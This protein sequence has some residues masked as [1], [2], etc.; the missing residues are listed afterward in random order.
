MK[1]TWKTVDLHGVVIG[2]GSTIT[3][4]KEN[5][6]ARIQRAFADTDYNPRFVRFPRGE[7]GTVYHTLEGWTY[8]I[9]WSDQQEKLEYGTGTY[10][11]KQEALWFLKRHVAQTYVLDTEDDG[12]SILDP[13]DTGG[14][15]AH[16]RYIRFQRAY[17]EL[18]A[19]GHDPDTC[20]RLACQ[21]S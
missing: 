13:L 15:E 12:L 10:D 20:H 3:R 7:V 2:Q 9:L 1:A 18:K 8:G 5:A 6:V 19:Q 14:Q 17:A 16:R 11:G 4:A 21:A